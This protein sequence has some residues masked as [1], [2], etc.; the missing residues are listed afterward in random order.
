MTHPIDSLKATLYPGLL[1]IIDVRKA[2]TEGASADPEWLRAALERVA[3]KALRKTWR[4][5]L[6]PA[7]REAVVNELV[8]D[9]M[10]L[11]PLAPFLKD[12][13]VTEIMVN[14]PSEVFV[15][16][17]GRIERVPRAFRDREHLLAVVERILSG[18]G[19]SVTEARPYAE[20]SMADGSRVHVVMPPVA[21]GGPYVT[22]RKRLA[23]ELSLGELIRREG[24]SQPAA[25]LLHRGVQA[26]L[27]I[28]VSGQA[29][30]GKTTLLGALVHAVPPAERIVLLEETPELE[31]VHPHLVRLE[32]RPP[33][34]AGYG[35]ITF[36]DL[37]RQALH[38]RPD[39]L[40]IGEVR[41]AEAFDLL[42]AMT[43][44]H[45]GSMTTIHADS[46][47]DALDRLE[48]LALF[49][50]PDLSSLV[51]ARQVRSAVDL[52]VHLERLTDGSRKVVRVS[53]VCKHPGSGGE[54]TKELFRFVP[55]AI[56]AGSRVTGVLQPR[57]APP[58]STSR[59]AEGSPL[60]V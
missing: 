29:A 22:I 42:Q 59:S 13:S 31:R 30:S 32:A 9:V 47:E 3:D 51:V 48:T 60:D 12:P 8:D 36:R 7:Q 54:R 39:R 4:T 20:A 46:S 41:G 21:G 58:R 18:T 1:D 49:A 38:M 37:L 16:R 27:N 2:G 5:K 26:R 23:Q 35:E 10:G 24:I 11:G 45:D 19:R 14:G 44:G 6:S 28:V 33:N 52:I 17:Q 34:V 56:E 50:S 15:E 55:E 53:E 57:H 40:V 43:T 25:E